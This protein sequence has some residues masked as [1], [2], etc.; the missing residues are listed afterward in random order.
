[1]AGGPDHTICAVWWWSRRQ[2]ADA[3]VH[4]VLPCCQLLL[5]VCRSAAFSFCLRI[6]TKGWWWSEQAAHF[7]SY[8][9][10]QQHAHVSDAFIVCCKYL[11]G[12]S[13]V[14]RIVYLRGSHVAGNLPGGLP[15]HGLSFFALLLS[16]ISLL[17]SG[18]MPLMALVGGRGVFFS[19]PA[20]TL[21]V[22]F[23]ALA[24]LGQQ[25]G[26][27]LPTVLYSCVCSGM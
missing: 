10:A 26:W 9:P 11:E 23:S 25:V 1:M 18:Q 4:G 16:G 19:G 21:T 5:H 2:Q 8:E 3:C 24:P 17:K 20:D 22:C 6:A 15:C 12:L 7:P 14:K 27:L 13:V